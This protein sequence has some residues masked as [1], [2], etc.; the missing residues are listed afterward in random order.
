[1]LLARAYEALG[2]TA[3][4]RRELEL[5]MARRTGPEAY[6]RFGDHFIDLAQTA[7]L[8]GLA[9]HPEDRALRARIEALRAAGAMR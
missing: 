6:A 1:V 3:G 8:R 9:E 4:S 2:W 7:L 5:A